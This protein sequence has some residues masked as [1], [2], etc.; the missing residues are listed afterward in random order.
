MKAYWHQ[1]NEREQILISIAGVLLGLYI[2]YAF[3]YAPLSNSVDNAQADW[4]E[5][6]NTLEW[7]TQ[8]TRSYTKG[9]APQQVT[10]ANL[11]S[12][13]T[14]LLDKASFHR[15][16]YQLEQTAGGDIQLTFTEV[17]Y[18]LF[19]VWL[20]VQS[21]HYALGIKTLSLS[22]VEVSGLVKAKVVFTVE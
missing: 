2:L 12:V 4:V 5:K 16:P 14:A 10:S 7:I 6:K 21:Q 15:F 20:H 1:L 18:N 8:A 11:L 9:Q 3:I 19:M 22:K 13:L 17:P